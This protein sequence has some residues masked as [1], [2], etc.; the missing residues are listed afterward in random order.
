MAVFFPKLERRVV[1]AGQ[2]ARLRVASYYLEEKYGVLLALVERI[3]QQLQRLRDYPQQWDAQPAM[4]LKLIARDL[5]QMR[6]D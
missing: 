3:V 5:S 2:I 1:M 4:I 6:D